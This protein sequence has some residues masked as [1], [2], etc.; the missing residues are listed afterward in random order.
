MIPT[1][2][3]NNWSPNGGFGHAPG[4]LA[5]PGMPG[6]GAPQEGTGL[7]QGAGMNGDPRAGIMAALMKQFGAGN[8]P[9]GAPTSLGNVEQQSSAGTTASSGGGSN[10]L[11]T[12]LAIANIVAHFL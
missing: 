4:G 10:G 9:T 12:A 6:Q 1:L 8:A 5:M 3:N 7:P 2:M 11:Q